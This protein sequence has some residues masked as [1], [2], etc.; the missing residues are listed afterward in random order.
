MT[1]ASN[2]SHEMQLRVRIRSS[3]HGVVVATAG[4]CQAQVVGGAERALTADRL[5]VDRGTQAVAVTEC[6]YGATK[7]YAMHI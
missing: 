1:I 2:F 7:A 4:R 5:C 6:R 3:M